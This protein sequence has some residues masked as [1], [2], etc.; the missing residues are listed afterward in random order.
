MNSKRNIMNSILIIFLFC[1]NCSLPKYGVIP[2]NKYII[3]YSNMPFG[4][5]REWFGAD[6]EQYV[7]D[8]FTPTL[9]ETI[10]AD[11]IIYKTIDSI[12]EPWNQSVIA[13]SK[14]SLITTKN[15]NKYIRQYSGSNNNGTK[16]IN[17]SFISS[18]I[19]MRYS[20]EQLK[21]RF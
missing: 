9:E 7:V 3:P 13:I 16:E 15:L 10:I 19:A 2:T 11:S 20:T 14:K 5:A 4:N 18:D 1:C 12:A 6:W 21:N 8:Y 17:V